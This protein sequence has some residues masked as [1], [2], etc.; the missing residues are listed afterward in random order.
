MSENLTIISERVDDIPL[1][2]AQLER[3]GVQSLLDEHFPPHGN[4]EG[5]S[6][7]WVGVLWLTHI[8]A[9]AD[10]RLNH[11][12]PWAEQRLHSLRGCTGQRLHPLDVSDDRRAGML[13]AL[14][15]DARW[16]TFAG[17]LHQPRLR[18]YD[19]QPQRVRLESTL[20]S[21]SW[22]VTAAGLVQLGHRKDHRPELPQVKGMLA[23][24]DPLGLPV[25]TEVVPG[26]RADA[27]LYVPAMT[28][29]RASLARR[30]LLY[31]GDGKLGARE[32]RA[33]LQAGGDDYVCPLS[34]LQ[35]PSELLEE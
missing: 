5:L 21:G 20:A 18:V 11:V 30:G 19:L 35:V 10:H 16:R 17:A 13:A 15:D 31:V 33:C 22:G 1:L 14:S 4:W 2:L 27:P 25:A 3:M 28:R 32:T 6:L 29:G 12:E 9:Q 7:G 24:L 26:Q 34:A 8:L 23:A